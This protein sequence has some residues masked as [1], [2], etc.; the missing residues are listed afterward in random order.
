[1]IF[2]KYKEYEKREK[3]RQ[4]IK[5]LKSDQMQIEDKAPKMEEIN[6]DND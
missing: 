6:E 1:M 3:N 5:E 2:S 4:N